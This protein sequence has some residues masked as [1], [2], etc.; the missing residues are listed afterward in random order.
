MAKRPDMAVNR[1]DQVG[2]EP[3]PELQAVE[4][5][6]VMPCLNEATTLPACIAKARAAIAE[7]GLDA[8]IVVADN[9]STDNSRGIARAM[10]ARVVVATE[11]GYGAAIR[12]GIEAARGRYVIVG[13]ADDSYDFSQI[14][15]FI[16]RLRQ[17][18]DL[19]VGNRFKGGID[20]AAMP[21]LHRY[22]GNPLLSGIGRILFHVRIGD[23]HC[24]MRAL[25]KDAYERMGLVGTG[26]EFASEMVIKAAAKGMRIEEV[27]TRLHRDGRNRPPHL[28]SFR[29][30]WRH[31]RFMLLFSPR[32]LFV[33]PGAVL[34]LL[35]VVGS[36]WLITG[37]KEI[38]RFGLDIHTLL[39][40]GFLCLLGYQTL[41][42]GV[43]TKFFA[44]HQ[45]FNAPNGLL[46]TLGKRITLEVGLLVG[47]ALVI[48]GVAVLGVAVVGW[49]ASGFGAL[50]PRV[51]MRQV[52]PAFVLLALGV[53]TVFASF[54]V[55]ILSI[56]ARRPS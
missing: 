26:M 1:L 35:G 3:T 10:G 46:T 21:W 40:A 51:T 43:F 14:Y 4:V 7:H 49:S 18:S 41:I 13:D 37:P 33:A 16:E 5:S 23:F 17:G 9:G 6:I 31:L 2:S 22:L 29:D 19:V 38:G 47:L 34:F 8:E 54:F 36:A 11:R 55:S 45:G 56:S 48:A 42:F 52:I 39:A 27:P 30:G 20:T 53:Q 15:P 32:W 50:D 12:S 44:I 28:R 25:R 24:G